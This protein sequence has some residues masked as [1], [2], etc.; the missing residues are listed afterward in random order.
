MQMPTNITPQMRQ[1]QDLES[2]YDED[3]HERRKSHTG[4]NEFLDMGVPYVALV[5]ALET[6][7]PC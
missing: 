6:V 4:A 5:F 3:G 1:C 2:S 7:M